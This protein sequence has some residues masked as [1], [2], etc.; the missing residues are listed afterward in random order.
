MNRSLIPACV[1]LVACAKT[2]SPSTVQPS[3][4][5]AGVVS[6]SL[7]PHAGAVDETPSDTMISDRV[8]DA[9]LAD[10]TIRRELGN[11][12]V[13][14]KD[15]V[16]TL[17]GTVRNDAI[18]YRMGS[19]AQAVGSV[20]RVVNQLSIDPNA[21][22]D[23]TMEGT[24]DHV[25]SDRVRHALEQD[26]ALSQDVHAIGVSTKDGAVTLTGAVSSVAVKQRAVVVANAVGSV[27]RVNDQ[28]VVK[29][30]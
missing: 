21:P 29:R 10:N 1:L 3:I 11:V 30:D 14:T 28:L 26:A 17:S 25:I 6:A 9:L 22:T 8:R 16:V 5:E 4:A 20:S 18:A 2:E 12:R 24:L 23:G 7:A 19:I 15:A 13:D 27:V